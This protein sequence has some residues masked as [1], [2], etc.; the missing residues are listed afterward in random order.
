MWA[1]HGPK[2]AAFMEKLIRVCV[3]AEQGWARI[4]K[5]EAI[6]AKVGFAIMKQVACHWAEL[7]SSMDAY[8][9][10]ELLPLCPRPGVPLPPGGPWLPRG[11]VEVSQFQA[12]PTWSASGPPAR[13]E[14]QREGAR[15][16]TT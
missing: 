2:G 7:S 6:R 8:E 14:G 13:G 12:D 9:D 1:G 3:G 11:D 16:D 4:R 15:M 10:V 5:V